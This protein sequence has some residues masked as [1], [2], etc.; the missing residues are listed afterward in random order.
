MYT[1]MLC[2]LS[3]PNNAHVT[4]R[5]CSDVIAQSLVDVLLSCRENLPSERPELARYLHFFVPAGLLVQCH[6]A[7][8][9][10]VIDIAEVAWWRKED[11]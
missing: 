6:T 8:A 3:T 7:V 10:Y 11:R 4:H 9:H 5:Q 1:C 2:C